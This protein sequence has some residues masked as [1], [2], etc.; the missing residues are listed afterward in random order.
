MLSLRTSKKL[1]GISSRSISE[2]KVNDLF[3]IMKSCPDLWKQAYLNIAPNHGA[4]TKG[5][6]GFSI[7]GFS[8]DYIVDMI[9]RL[10]D[11]RYVPKPVRRVYI[12]KADGKQRPLG[13][14][15]FRD[16]LVQEVCRLLL[17]AVYEPIFSDASHGFRPNRSCHTAL[18]AVKTWSGTVWFI[19][20]D[21]KS[22]FDSISHQKLVEIL[23]KQIDDRRF[24]KL[25]RKIIESGYMEN[26]KV[27]E[28][29]SG[30]PQGGVISP[31][32]ANIFLNELD[33]MIASIPFNKGGIVRRPNPEYHR[34]STQIR[35]I[36]KKVQTREN[37]L[38]QGK[39]V[40]WGKEK[41]LEKG[42][43]K[44]FRAEIKAL[45]SQMKD[46][47]ER[48]LSLES[49]DRFDPN[50]KRLRYVRYADDFLIGVTGS[51]TEAE[52]I[53]QA[54][55]NFIVSKLG[56]EIAESKTGIRHARD[57]GARFL[58]YEISRTSNRRMIRREGKKKRNPGVTIH[59]KVPLDRV[60]KFSSKYGH[61]DRH[62]SLH[63][64][65]LLAESDAELVQRYNAE[66]R[67]FA[68][69]YALADDVKG[70]LH[71]LEWLMSGSFLKTMAN[72]HKSHIGRVAKQLRKGTTLTVV[73]TKTGKEYPLF[74]L[75]NL[76]TPKIANDETRRGYHS[77]TELEDRMQARKCEYCGATKGYFE[78]HH[79]RKLK[80]LKGKTDWE[81]RMMEK[82]RKTLVLCR[83]CHHALHKNKLPDLRN[84]TK[85]N[86]EP[87]ASKG[88]RTVRG[89]VKGGQE[90][91]ST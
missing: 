14:P 2:G 21:I 6:D 87:Y 65:E 29:Y 63:R 11:D 82:A 33:Q 32:L 67:G 57:E 27:S 26:S 35:C 55:R 17:E 52:E 53:E 75:R 80:D 74:K 64:P 19:E 10:E 25:I 50:F 42:D 54:V 59:L 49:H 13:I 60:K 56:L 58:N 48:C 20:F 44:I 78:V 69:Y 1:E 81:R 76:T 73:S 83:T 23:S 7:D 62:K 39:K 85:N 30:T 31:I 91:G 86:G 77:K 88:A 89:G 66:F 12:P 79:V 37:F 43:D 72:K 22:F 41:P 40:V 28:T 46:L 34:L 90:R 4:M 9:K 68:N 47:R 70:K 24:L 45:S 15:T 5:V 3:K 71:K 18:K 51:R 61:W 84:L 38:A 16:K 36:K 8:E